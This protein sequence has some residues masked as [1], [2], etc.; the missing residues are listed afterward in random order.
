[1]TSAPEYRA[2]SALGTQRIK[3][4]LWLYFWLLLFEGALRK[5]GIPE[6]SAPL[7][8]IRDPVA[9]AAYYLGL[10][11]GVFYRNKPLFWIMALAFVFL[12]VSFAQYF[13]IN[14]NLI[15]TL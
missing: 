4:V 8:V 7:L 10:R 15:V 6:L 5:W 1:M 14:T 9:I 3:N 12:I 13:I 2:V 11:H